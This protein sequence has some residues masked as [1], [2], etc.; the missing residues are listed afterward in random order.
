[1]LVNVQTEA[2][3]AELMLRENLIWDTANTVK[4]LEEN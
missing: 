2:P 3:E 4:L 1:M